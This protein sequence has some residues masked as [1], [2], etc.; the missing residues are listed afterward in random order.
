MSACG[1]A[2]ITGSETGNS[3]SGDDFGVNN[4]FIGDQ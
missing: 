3:A 4:Q 1:S 2:R